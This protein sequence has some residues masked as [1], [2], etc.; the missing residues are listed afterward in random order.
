VLCGVSRGE[1]GRGEWEICVLC[2]AGIFRE[3]MCPYNDH[4][5]SV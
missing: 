3:K 4:T 5:Y 2:Y 1:E